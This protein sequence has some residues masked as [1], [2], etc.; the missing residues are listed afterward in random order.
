[1]HPRWR[2]RGSRGGPGETST[3]DFRQHFPKTQLSIPSHG[4]IDPTRRSL[5]AIEDRLAGARRPVCPLSR[6]EGT[7]RRPAFGANRRSAKHRQIVRVPS[8]SGVVRKE[9]RRRMAARLT[10][11]RAA[12]AIR[13]IANR[14]DRAR[15]GT[16][17]AKRTPRFGLGPRPAGRV[18]FR[19]CCVE[20]K[21]NC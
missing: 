11:R 7:T 21:V 19:H 20:T 3:F 12:V 4:R 9:K 13:C 18:V 14:S 15:R 5:V 2:R 16:F 1:M 17:D 10:L 6:R 8:A